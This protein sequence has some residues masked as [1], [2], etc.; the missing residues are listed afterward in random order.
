MFFQSQLFDFAFGDQGPA[1]RGAKAGPSG[2]IEGFLTRINQL[3][4]HF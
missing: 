1:A 2:H 4:N 3:D